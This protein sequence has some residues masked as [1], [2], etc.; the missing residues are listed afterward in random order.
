MRY[1]KYQMLKKIEKS[2]RIGAVFIGLASAVFL[3]P[4]LSIESKA[5][6]ISPTIDV[7]EVELDRDENAN[8]SRSIKAN[9]YENYSAS[10]GMYEESIED[11]FFFYCNVGNGSFTS[12]PVKFD[13]P[14][15]ISYVIEKDGT[16]VPYKSGDEIKDI[17]NYVVRLSAEMEGDTY[18]ATFRFSL[19]EALA[20]AD[21]S[22]IQL[23]GI[24]AQDMDNF[25]LTEDD[26]TLDVN[27][28]ITDE[29]INQLIEQ[30]GANFGMDGISGIS[31]GVAVNAY[32][33]FVR[34]FEP[35]TMMYSITLKSGEK[36]ISNVPEGA[37][38]NG[39]VALTIPADVTVTVYKDGTALSE[40]TNLNF[41][42]PGFYKV[43][44]HSQTTN[45]YRFYP[46]DN[47]HPFITFRIVGA[48]VNDMEVFTA[49][50]GCKITGIY[51]EHGQFTDENGSAE[52]NLDSFWM[53]SEGNYNFI[54]FDPEAGGSYEVKINRDITAPQ[55]YVNL[56]KSSAELYFESSDIG[57]IDVYRS[58]EQIP[59]EGPYFVGRGDYV[60][61]VYDQAGNLTTITFTLKDAFNKGTFFTFLISFILIATAFVYIRLQRT[62]IRTR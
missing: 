51:N 9:L 61:N 22:N 31:E 12:D 1:Q 37:I 45:F 55:G 6:E 25:N 21:N 34:N 14:G 24:D 32:T 46:D 58:G 35:A 36:I 44:F 26:L 39:G 7:D 42:D 52:F 8:N 13:F 53:E 28:E 3:M 33:G 56:T 19:K 40:A 48:A 4:A 50:A 5:T 18:I 23:D 30:S 47:K 49:P 20:N 62:Y 10:Y 16:E 29:Q 11:L 15:N 27:E 38:V 60:L 41:T 54:I 57:K 17:G 2:V 59:Y 43:V